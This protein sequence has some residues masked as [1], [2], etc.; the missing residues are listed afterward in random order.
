MNKDLKVIKKL[1]D[2][3]FSILYAYGPLNEKEIDLKI[4]YYFKDLVDS[5]GDYSTDKILNFLVDTKQIVKKGKLYTVIPFNIVEITNKEM[6]FP[7]EPPEKV[8]NNGE[9][10]LN[11]TCLSNKENIKEVRELKNYLKSL[12]IKINKKELIDD[13]LTSI[14]FTDYTNYLK[15]ALSELP[16][17]TDFNFINEKK[18]AI[19]K[20]LPRFFLKGN[21]FE[22]FQAFIVS[23]S[24]VHQI[25]SSKNMKIKEY[26]LKKDYPNF[27]YEDCIELT[28]RFD[29]TKLCNMV[30]SDRVLELTINGK[31]RYV[32]VLGFHKKDYG[33][34][35]YPT[36]DEFKQMYPFILGEHVQ[37]YPD[38]AYHYNVIEV[39]MVDP[40]NMATDNVR[41]QM[42][43]MGYPLFPSFIRIETNH[44]IRLANQE[45][46]N[47]IGGVLSDLLKMMSN[48][49]FSEICL[50]LGD[51]NEKYDDINQVYVTDEETLFGSYFDPELGRT[52]INFE[53]DQLNKKKVKELLTL[54]NKKDLFI[55]LFITPFTIDCYMPYLL[56]IEDAENGFVYGMEVFEEDR[57]K[58]IVNYLVRKLI[59]LGIC[60]KSLGFNNEYC[61]E[62]F[63]Q[64]EMYFDDYYVVE[65]CDVNNVYK[66]LLEMGDDE[67]SLFS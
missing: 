25:N 1:N 24:T 44:D 66:R 51:K 5:F 67:I 40:K 60:P 18:E 52:Y 36:Y 45:E 43:K 10:L 2:V 9:E 50:H 65:E 12:N 30:D 35:I 11:I 53:L 39:C 23:E 64:L 6:Q 20:M 7:I 28:K 14:L 8:F 4:R 42:K 27:T 26:P 19:C 22:E 3:V 37:D 48:T 31:K 55:G 46:I 33:L 61:A 63:L 59:E 47:I 58:D 38:I 21:S 56:V 54:K 34:I 57:N 41:K 17:D 16:E 13:I 32:S 29:I 62:V 15:E 49:D